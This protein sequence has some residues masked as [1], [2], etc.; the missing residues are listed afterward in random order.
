MVSLFSPP[1]WTGNAG[2]CRALHVL[3][4]Y[5]MMSTYA[6]MLCEAIFLRMFLLKSFLDEERCVKI[7]CFTGWVVPG[8]V[9]VPYIA[10]RL[11]YEN[12]KCWMDTGSSVWFLAVPV[13][14]VIIVNVFC[15]CNVLKI[16]QSKLQ[17]QSNFY[18][19]SRRSMSVPITIK[20]IKAAVILIPIFGLQ[21]LL[22]P[23]R[24]SKGSWLEDS[25]HIFSSLSTSTQGITVSFLLC[26]SNNEV[27]KKL[28][29]FFLGL[30]DKLEVRV[31][32]KS[33]LSTRVYY[34]YVL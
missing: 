20:S 19:S 16:I 8:L 27:L 6:W 17:F 10:F 32:S 33:C 13:I 9:M 3:T 31:I 18:V 5:F 15:L 7:L 4:T 2:W 30:K 26:F 24:P 29:R 34:Y 14:L 11:N 12:E 21:F 22:L 1:V 28:T 25:Y 23:I